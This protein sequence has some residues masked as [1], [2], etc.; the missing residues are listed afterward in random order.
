MFFVLLGYDAVQQSLHVPRMIEAQVLL[1]INM[2][3]CMQTFPKRH[4]NVTINGLHPL[5]TQNSR[6]LMS[7]S[8]YKFSKAC[9]NAMRQTE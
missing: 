8:M 6:L 2:H 4:S 3:V 1:K 7:F 5:L 9:Q